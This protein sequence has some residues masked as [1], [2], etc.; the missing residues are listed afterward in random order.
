LVH[1]GNAKEAIKKYIEIME[2]NDG[3]DG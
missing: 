2:H 3:K 1:I